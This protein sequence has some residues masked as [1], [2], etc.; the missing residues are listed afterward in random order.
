[1]MLEFVEH[2]TNEDPVE[3]ILF[4]SGAPKSETWFFLSFFLS[5]GV[6]S[7]AIPWC[8]QHSISAVLCNNILWNLK[9]IQ[10]VYNISGYYIHHK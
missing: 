8:S 2:F 4:E 5:T 6:L 7:T 1:M 3:E 10:T 9:H